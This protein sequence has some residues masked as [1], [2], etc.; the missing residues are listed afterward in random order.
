MRLAPHLFLPVVGAVLLVAA[1]VAT[2]LWPEAPLPEVGV[3]SA[4]RPALP[5]AA[6]AVPAPRPAPRPV[7]VRPPPVPPPSVDVPPA[8]V[9]AVPPPPR[10]EAPSSAPVEFPRQET[11]PEPPEQQVRA[12]P[13]MGR[14]MA[15]VAQRLGEDQARLERERQEAQRRGDTAEVERLE[16]R[17]ELNHKRI[18]TMRTKFPGSFEQEPAPAPL[19]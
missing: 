5:Q 2:A 17:I 6:P 14:S 9:A 10:A 3:S 1:V 8:A 12:M 18:G 15:R 19:Q 11:A 16:K 13:W 4:P 7:A